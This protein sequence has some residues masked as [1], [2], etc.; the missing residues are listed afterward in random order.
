[1]HVL[2]ATLLL[3][4]ALPAFSQTGR[5][6]GT[7]AD[8]TSKKTIPYATVALFG[9]DGQLITG[10]ATTDQGQ[11][12]LEKLA[13]GTYK[14][15]VSFVGYKTKTVAALV[16]SADKPT[17]DLGTLT[18]TPGTSTLAE[19]TV[20]AVK[21]MVEDKGDRLVY[22]AEQDISNA[23]GTAVDLMR[24]VPMLTVDLTGNL[25]MRGSSNIKVLVNGKPSSIMAR[26][27]ADALKQMP[28]N[29]IKAV[30]VITSPGAKYDAEGSA[31]VINII[32]KKNVKG[33]NGS[34]NVSAGNLNSSVG[35]NLAVKG[36]KLS[37]SVSGNGNE[38]RMI[39]TNETTRTALDP[40]TGQPLS[41]L[42]Q[43]NQSDNTGRGG[44]G[45]LALDYDP[46][47]SNRITLSAN[48]WG[49]VYPQNVTLLNQLT[50][51]KAVVQ[52]YTR[53]VQFKNP[54]GNG[55]FNLGWTRTGKK[56]GQ[57]F[58]VL[59]QYSHMPDNY[60]YTAIQTNSGGEQPSYLE[61]STN[62][63]RNNEYTI[64]TDYAYPFTHKGHRDTLTYK[65]ELGAKAILRNIGSEF[66][67]DQSPTGNT[68][69]YQF[70]PARSSVFTYAQQVAGAY[71]SLRM[72]SKRKWSLTGGLRYEHTGITGDFVTD[73]ATFTNQY[74][75]LIPSLTV[76]KTRGK[77]TYKL[78]YTQ[79][80]SR[81]Q[82]WYLNPYLNASDAQNL[83]TGNPYLAPE[84]THAT[85]LAYSTYNDKG[86]SLN[87]A[88][89]WRQ[90]N[91][92]IEFLQ[93]VDPNGVALTRPENIGRNASY[94]LNTSLN[95]QPSKAFSISSGLDLTY[96][97]LV[98]TALNQRNAGLTWSLNGNASYKLPHDWTLQAYATYTSAWIGLQ[99]NYGSYTWYSFA[100]K[101]ELMAK[102]A[103]LTLALNNPFMANFYQSSQQFAPTFSTQTWSVMRQRNVQLTFTYRF[104]KSSDSKESRKIKNDD[105]KGGR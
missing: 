39:Y 49:G 72:E 99:G 23:G 86:M 104:G 91:N 71:A 32:T 61:R 89:Y 33:V 87:A 98:S 21:P 40:A 43:R 36:Q 66:T 35:G 57:E 54:Y 27:L 83:Q 82:I 96:V 37:L 68:I 58:S 103:D 73:R 62:L 100:T 60:Y 97:N 65:L 42:F 38:H 67:V 1:M 74:G 7:L 6:V 81:P 29:T 16:L 17:L 78:S 53:N 3:F 11:F 50:V 77:H 76:A 55:E 88:A 47:S 34:V 101:K 84:L 22:N 10:A 52:D 30:E 93:T 80:I 102:K 20:T 56:P 64:Q 85:E 79:R 95:L 13:F 31:G 28:A 90:T 44:Y 69:D 94:G 15:T 59:T 70:D 25:T 18:L 75:N 12:N 4:L 2:Y 92:S 48:V 8:S 41:V 24:K 9:A 63:S 45:D 46:D 14:L 5:I 19:V 51:G 105:T 26:N